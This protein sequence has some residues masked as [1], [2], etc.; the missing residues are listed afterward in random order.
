MCR[1]F[2]LTAGGHRVRATFWLL[3]APDSLRE[4]SHRMPDGTGIGTFAEDGR[5]LVDKQPLAA[6][7]DT[8]F[9]TAARE[10]TGST[11]VAHVRYAT[12][13]AL[14]AENTHPFSQGGRLLAHNGVVHG[15]DLLDDR[16]AELGAAD[17]VHGNSDSERVFALITAETARLDG[18]VTQGLTAALT[19]V[20]VTLPVF[21]LNLV[22]VSPTDLWG[23]RYPDTH[24]L[25]VLQRE[26]GQSR[27]AQVRSRRIRASSDDLDDTGSVVVASEPMDGETGWRLL[28]PGELIHVGPD[29]TVHSSSPVPPPSQPLTLADLHGAAA[30]AQSATAQTS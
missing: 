25:Y 3:D 19:W 15:L 14:T 20:A 17:L 28:D 24:R 9:A 22:L 21:A 6:W 5:P 7:E 4:Q 26:A 11:F 10:L 29:L 16:L 27:P 12:T 23:L 1:L 2:G 8:E 30:A 13:G 18:D